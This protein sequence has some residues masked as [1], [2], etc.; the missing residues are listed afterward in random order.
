MTSGELAGATIVF[1]LDGTLVD[2]AP[3]LTRA[4]NATMDLEGLPHLKI[5]AVRSMVGLGARKLLERVATLRGLN[6]SAAKLDDLTE[7]YTCF[8]LEDIA[9]SSKPFP[10][11]IE[12]MDTLAAL[13]AKFAICTNKRTHLSEKLM[14]ALGLS[15]RFSAIVG[16]D[17]V[18]E[19]KPHP[20]HYR[21]TVE[22]AG[23][24]V[25]RS[26]MIGDTTIDVAA[27]RAAGAPAAIVSF[28]YCDGDPEKLGANVV[29]HRYAE[30]AP[31]CRRLLAARP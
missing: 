14:D 31:A 18:P 4:L 16:A 12:A 5:D 17:A 30:L 7:A 27:A 25:R 23:G 3:D 28:G 24:V 21:A 8:Y 10:G 11:V 13:G 22:R 6:Y 9:G 1:D 26:V 15:D 29:L 20:G 2:T 19:R